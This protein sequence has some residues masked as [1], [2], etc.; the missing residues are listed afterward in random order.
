MVPA[1]TPYWYKAVHG[2][3]ATVA[4]H[5]LANNSAL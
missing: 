1:N 5:M 3:L 2:E 4:V